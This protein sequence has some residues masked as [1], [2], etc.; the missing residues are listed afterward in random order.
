MQVDHVPLSLA[1]GTAEKTAVSEDFPAIFRKAEDRMYRH[2]LAE[3]RSARSAVLS[4]L[5]E[6]LREKSWETKEHAER[7][8]RLARRLGEAVGLCASDLDR[9][10]LLNTLHD[11]GKITLPDAVLRKPGPLSP[12]EWV[13]VR[14][15]PETGYRIAR[16]TDELAHIAEEILAHHER[17][18]GSGYPRE[19]AGEAIPLL[20]RLSAIVD[21]YDA[22]T[23][24]RPYRETLRP[25]EALG[26][27]RRCAGTQLDP[28][29]VE[30]F[31]DLFRDAISDR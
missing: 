30:R 13:L 19:L 10:A 16:S 25:D 6:T 23:N 14:Q 5:Q 4:A 11:I 2:K 9:L 12:E 17:W 18:D 29:L 3:S 26:E 7:V 28:A 27:L 20:S 22:M 24:H 15:H 1:L 8:E 31:V 21:A